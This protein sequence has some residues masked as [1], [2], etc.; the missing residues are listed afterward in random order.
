M[1]FG[2][3]PVLFLSIFYKIFPVILLVPI[4]NPQYLWY[5]TYKVQEKKEI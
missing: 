4:D 2:T 3:Y 5:N 1:C